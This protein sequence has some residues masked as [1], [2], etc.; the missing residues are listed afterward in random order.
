MDTGVYEHCWPIINANNSL[1]YIPRLVIDSGEK[2]KS[3]KSVEKA[4][5]FLSNN[6][7]NRNS[8]VINFGGGMITDLGGFVASTFKRGCNFINIPTNITFS[9]RCLGRRK[10]RFQF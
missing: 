1:D 3:L 5:E 4:W 6:G 8:L 7:A 9:N 10:N 2:N